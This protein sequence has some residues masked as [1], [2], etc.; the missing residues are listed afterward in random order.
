MDMLKLPRRA[1]LAAASLLVCIAAAF[2]PGAAAAK[3]IGAFTTKGAWSF[4]SAPA[5][6]PPKLSNVGRPV[7]GKL[8][9]GYVILA[10]FKNIGFAGPMVGQS[11]PM[12]LDSHLQPVWF[13]P[14][15]AN[16]L[17]M[18]LEVQSYNG[19]PALSWWQG[20]ISKTGV[21]VSGQDVVVGQDYRTLATLK[22]DTKN[23]WVISPH[24]MVISGHNAW[25]TAYRNVPKDLTAE[26]GSATGVLLDSAI[27][28]YD[29]QTGALLY[30]WDA[31]D[32]I[33]LTQSKL[34]PGAPGTLAAK[35]P[36]DAYHVNSIQLMPDGTS[37]LVSMR[38]T[39]GVYLVDMATKNIVWT[40]G[41]SGSNFRFGP[42][43]AF[44]WQHDARLSSAGVLTMFDDACCGFKGTGLA[45]PNG[46]SR[47]LVLRL[48]A[49]A[50]TA[51]R[52]A[53]F[54][55]GKNFAAAFLGS[56]QP[57]PGGNAFVGWGSQPYFT[58]FSAS[59]KVLLDALFP[60]PDQSYRAYLKSWIGKPSFPPAGAVRTLRG[61]TT[62]YASWDG[63]TLV[64][65]WRLL[66]GTSSKH[67]VPVASARR[68]GFESA[69]TLVKSYKA[70]KVQALDRAGHVL[71][72]SAVFPRKKVSRPFY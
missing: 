46:P 56:M 41:G 55:R 34:R 39:W 72:T 25:V 33:P 23:G 13:N 1:A 43:A 48:D 19:Q 29:L 4:Y 37:F 14:V 54:E 58:E 68:S 38:N 8:A 15:P 69:I 47:G 28:E 27:Q 50:H 70:Y 24:E 67:L 22:G 3:P 32:R 40:L 17:A 52:V 60:T 10:N 21:T 64:T 71:G 18:N 5:L 63:A 7:R 6:H 57:L 12:I 31:L 61:R 65:R 35:L 49:T 16:N 30:T 36:W 26:H 45:P 42:H 11:G 59:G 66:A 62:V 44:S 53:Q 20:V 2:L 51:T 9:R